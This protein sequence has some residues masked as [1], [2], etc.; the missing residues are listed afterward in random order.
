[1]N[2]FLKKIRNF[3]AECDFRGRKGRTWGVNIIINLIIIRG[4]KRKQ[5]EE[6]AKKEKSKYNRNLK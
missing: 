4:G 3:F 1:L 2:S 6:K 5:E